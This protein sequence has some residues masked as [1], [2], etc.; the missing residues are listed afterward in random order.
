MNLR[1][2]S[3]LCGIALVTAISAH[4]QVSASLRLSKNQYL[5]GEA[6]VAVVTITNNSGQD[7]VF[8]T[9][10]RSP[11]LDFV[12]KNNQ[13]EPAIPKGRLS[14]GAVKI[15]AGQTM[16]RQVV[17]NSCFQLS[18]VGSYSIF[19]VVRTPG[20]STQGYS[21]NRVLFNL[22]SGRPFWTQ[23]VGVKGNAEKIR[24]YRVMNYSGEQNTQL[25]VQVMD[26][27]NGTPIQTFPLG[28]VL[29]IRKPQISVDKNQVLHVFY[30]STPVLWTHARVDTNGKLLSRDFHL[31]GPAGDPQ[32]VTFGTGEIGV[33]NSI[34]Y[35]PKAA[36]AAKAKVRKASDRPGLY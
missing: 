17:L 16:A 32:M 29:M 23:K 7:Q 27:L 4:G 3:R 13:E 28:D 19:G 36:A 34:P 21:T 30:L 33:S 5:A 26:S 25:Y 20:Q 31:R 24:E 35:D 2:F 1:F 9:T 11:W 15:P 10:S 8:Q 12:I 18:D 6:V 14:F 22:T